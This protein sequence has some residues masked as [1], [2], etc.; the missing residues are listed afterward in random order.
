MS[1]VSSRKCKIEEGPDGKPLQ[2][3]EVRKRSLVFAPTTFV[4]FFEL[5]LSSYIIQILR[6]VLRQCPGKPVEEL[7]STREE[8]TNAVG[9]G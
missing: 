8:T 5:T 1:T 4:S 2:K 9:S 6:R 7:E 3:C